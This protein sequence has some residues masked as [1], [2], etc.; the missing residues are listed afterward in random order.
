MK[1]PALLFALIAMSSLI[2]S[3]SSAASPVE[4]VYG[5][6]PDGREVKIYTLTNAAGME[7][8][9]TEYGAILVSLTARN[10]HL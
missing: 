7:A 4:S 5:K 1:T 10:I 2:S 9:V 6:M 3:E 8:K